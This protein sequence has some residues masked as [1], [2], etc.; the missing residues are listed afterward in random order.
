MEIMRTFKLRLRPTAAQAD[1]LE[2]ICSA[3]RMVYN[4]ANEQ[5]LMYGRPQ[6]TDPHGR[7]SFFNHNRQIKEISTKALKHDPELSWLASAPSKSFEAALKD[8][9]QAWD[10]FFANVRKGIACERPGFRS[11]ARGD[12]SFFVPVPRGG[13]AM[14]TARKFN[15]LFNGRGVRLPKVGWVSMVKHTRIPG[16]IRTATVT[17]E[18]TRWFI[19]LTSKM[20]VVDRAPLEPRVGVDLGVTV[21]VM[22]STGKLMKVNARSAKAAKAALRAQRA[23][24][25][26]ARRSVRRKAR[27]VRLAALKRKEATRVRAQLHKASR[28]L[29]NQYGLIAIEDLKVSKMTRSGQGYGRGAG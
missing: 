16:D 27:V 26:S 1:E 12:V 7:D 24:S 5:R 17:R 4:A 28:A 9:D 14:K 20:Q 3:V 19:C 11:K 6:G 29:V 21:P 25:K 23:V 8:L 18:G 15:V 10:A 22:L 13:A 2:R